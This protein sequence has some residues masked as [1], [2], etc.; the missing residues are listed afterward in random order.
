MI[1][2]KS[3]NKSACNLR[4]DVVE[5]LWNATKSIQNDINKKSESLWVLL[6]QTVKFLPS[7]SLSFPY[8]LEMWN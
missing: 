5:L 2:F 7:L 3:G 1:L 8:S 4:G 6:P